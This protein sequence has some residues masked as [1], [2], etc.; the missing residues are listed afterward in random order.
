MET[1][2]TT[3]R[4]DGEPKNSKE[5]SKRLFE[6]PI[7]FS[8]RIL[9]RITFVDEQFFDH[10]FRSVHVR[11]DRARFTIRRLLKSLARYIF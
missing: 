6:F 3:R 1:R 9:I 11:Y 2:F 4:A 10:F 8:S 5:L 7:E